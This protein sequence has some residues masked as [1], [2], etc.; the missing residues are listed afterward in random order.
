MFLKNAKLQFLAV[1]G[2]GSAA[3]LCRSVRQAEPVP[4]GGRGTCRTA[5]GG[6]IGGLGRAG[7]LLGRPVQGGNARPGDP[8]RSRRR[9]GRRRGQEAEHRLHHG[10]RR[11]LVQHRRLPPRHHVR[12]DAEPRQ[13]GRRG[14]AV[15]RLLRRGE[16][17]GGSGQLHHRRDSPPHGPDDRRPGRRRRRHAGPGLHDRH[18]P[19]GAGLRHRPV[20]QEPP[21]RPEQVPA[22]LARLRRILRLPVPPRRHVGPVLVLLPLGPGVLQHLRAAATWCIAGRPT[23][24]TRR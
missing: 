5:E 12:Q 23:R 15:H 19:E 3:R 10:R 14:H 2:L 4:E 24:T 22:D 18:R 8:Q 16:L 9:E 7:L 21:G 17:H 11:R 6:R 1:L 13:A 20:R